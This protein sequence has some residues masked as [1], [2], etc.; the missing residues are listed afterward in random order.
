MNMYVRII[1]AMALMISMLLGVT[2]GTEP[3]INLYKTSPKSANPLSGQDVINIRG[4]G[5]E[6]FGDI[7]GNVKDTSG[8]GSFGLHA[9]LSWFPDDIEP[10]SRAYWDGPIWYNPLMD[11]YWGF[12]AVDLDGVGWREGIPRKYEEWEDD[13]TSWDKHTQY[14]DAWANEP[15]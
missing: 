7:R 8:Y 10:I 14:L 13:T 2:L 12:Q 11:Y 6:V 9:K 5:P 3:W 4:T 15:N 1:I